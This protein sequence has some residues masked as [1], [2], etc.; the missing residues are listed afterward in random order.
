MTVRRKKK[1]NEAGRK[2]IKK[3]TDRMR[4]KE[5]DVGDRTRRKW[6]REVK[7][8]RD[9]VWRRCRHNY[10]FFHHSFTTVLCRHAQQAGTALGPWPLMKYYHSG[11][12]IRAFQR[13]SQS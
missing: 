7:M 6:R 10:H 11:G 13:L 5:T 9:C 3:E 1:E 12:C 8:E 2:E 4:Q